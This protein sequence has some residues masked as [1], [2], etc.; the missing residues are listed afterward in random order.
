MQE[1]PL[2]D[3]AR[4][5]HHIAVP[6]AT[7]RRHNI[8]IKWERNEDD[9]GDQV[10]HGAHG[11]HALGDLRPAGLAE[12]AALETVR[13]EGGGQPADHGVGEAE[14]QNAQGQ[15]GEERPA[16]V[17]GDGLGK[18]GEGRSREGEVGEA[19]G[20]SE[21]RRQ[22]RRHLGCGRP[23]QSCIKERFAYEGETNV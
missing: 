15:R 16:R 13:H 18:E 10:H 22:G 21:G 4:L 11:A 17:G 5:Q 6:T 12:V 9:D 8:L 3:M 2:V 20:S 7:R 1:A 19:L 23:G 14:G